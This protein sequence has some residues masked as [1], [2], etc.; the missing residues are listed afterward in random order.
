MKLKQDNNINDF[1]AA[2]IFNLNK[3]A[4]EYN[5]F[6]NILFILKALFNNYMNINDGL[7]LFKLIIIYKCMLKNL[8]N[9]QLIIFKK[10]MQMV[11]I[12]RKHY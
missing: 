6:I 7:Q 3:E 9:V 1:L 8:I 4:A 2:L 5:K 11:N 10:R 12:Q